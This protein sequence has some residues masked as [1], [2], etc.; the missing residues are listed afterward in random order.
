MW[1]EKQLKKLYNCDFHNRSFCF[2]V[3]AL[4]VA[5]FFKSRI[6]IRKR[7]IGFEIENI[8]RF[9]SDTYPTR[10][11]TKKATAVLNPQELFAQSIKRRAQTANRRRSYEPSSTTL[12]HLINTTGENPSN[13][14]C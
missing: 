13:K 2:G 12:L 14:V 3:K 9:I 4:I 10:L 6:F 8:S 11:Q 1:L 5:C 7:R